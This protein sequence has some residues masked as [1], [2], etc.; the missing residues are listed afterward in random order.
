MSMDAEQFDPP[1]QFD[2]DD[3]ADDVLPL[4]PPMHRHFLLN[5][6][7]VVAVFEHVSFDR[8]F[9]FFRLNNKLN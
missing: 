8:V 9:F 7:V 2:D 6:A 4:P 3:E 1:E 5:V